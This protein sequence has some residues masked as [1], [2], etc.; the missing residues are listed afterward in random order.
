MQS[1]V[2]SSEVA[3]FILEPYRAALAQVETKV[4]EVGAQLL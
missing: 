1:A 4:R 2:T 3:D